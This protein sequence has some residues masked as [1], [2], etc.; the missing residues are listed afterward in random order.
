MSDDRYGEGYLDALEHVQE[1]LT[2][3]SDWYLQGRAQTNLTRALHDISR[4]LDAW[5][6]TWEESHAS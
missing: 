3:E 1:L 6:D 5:K 2:D 4:T